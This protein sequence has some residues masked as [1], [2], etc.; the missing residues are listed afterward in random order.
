MKKTNNNPLTITRIAKELK[1]SP[2]TIS[3][4]FTS[5]GYVS[6]KTKKRI[7][8]YVKK[9]GFVPNHSASVLKGK[10]SKTL[11]VVFADIGLF[12]LEHNF[13][14]PIIQ[15][16]KN[17][18]EN[19][20]YEIVFIPKKIGEKEP[21]M[22]SWV[23]NKK[24]D[25]VLILTGNINNAQII[26]LVNSGIPC[27]SSDISMENLF[28][29]YSDDHHGINLAI[30]YL[31]QKG[32]KDIAAIS[33]PRTS[34][35]Y[36]E[37]TESYFLRMNQENM[38]INDLHPWYCEIVGYGYS[39]ALES[40]L[41][42]IDRW[43]E[44]P[45]T[46]LAFS[47]DIAMGLIK[48]LKVKG[49]RVPEDIKVIGYDDNNFSRMHTPALSTIRQDKKL[50]AEMCAKTLFKLIQNPREEKRQEIIKIPVT[51]VLRDSCP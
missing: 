14:G 31:T 47:D 24:V 19:E 4:T 18:V 48:A 28:S 41:S 6:E 39:S 21:S 12:G 38:P 25:G 33:G 15:A 26:E 49:M 36:A 37:R 23:K 22:L 32:I 20:G 16:F 44:K 46:I 29:I 27:V 45:N 17:Y 30:D 50:I 7:I 51:L 1:V 10:S 2:G 40:A 11:G 9:V 35:A 5:S 8:N 34:R 13:F 43:K 3:K 42:W